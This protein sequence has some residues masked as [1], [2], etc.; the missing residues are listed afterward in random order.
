[1][2]DTIP[3][4][5]LNQHGRILEGHQNSTRD[6]WTQPG[7]GYYVPVV[8]YQGMAYFGAAKRFVCVDDINNLKVDNIGTALRLQWTW[9]ANCEEAIVTFS[10]DRWPEPTAGTA[11]IYKI[12]RAQ[13][14]L[15]GHYDIRGAMNRDHFI[16][17]AAVIKQ[18]NDQV[19]APGIRKQARLASKIAL[20]YEIKPRLKFVRK[21][22]MLHL[23]IRVPGKLPT[24]LLVT[25]RNSLPFN[26]ADGELLYRLSAMELTKKE[27]S[28]PLPDSAFPPNTYCKL[29]LED[30]CMNDLINVY[31]PSMDKLRLD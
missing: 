6:E 8:I 11:N 14:D 3:Q 19:I 22:P 21:Q 25:K 29:F 5:T 13:Y 16:V 20:S 26:K 17:V 10:Y 23:H 9:P 7:I 2:G 15:H 1:V 31:Q 30:D 4:A 24:L 12:T 28:L 27:V 18:G